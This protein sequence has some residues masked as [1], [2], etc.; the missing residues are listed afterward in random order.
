MFGLLPL[1]LTL[2]GVI[3]WII[4]KYTYK[5]KAQDFKLGTN[6][7]VTTFAFFF[8]CYPQ[9]TSISFSLFNCVSFEDG[10]QYL[11][12]DM[13]IVCWEGEH[14]RMALAIGM[15]FIIIWSFVFPLIV[16]W[17]LKKGKKYLNT[18]HYLMVYGLFYVGLSDQA[19]FWELIIVNIRKIIFILC[20]S[21]ISASNQQ[22]KVS[23]IESY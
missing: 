22:Y 4:V 21:I 23:F 17:R 8:I 2:L 19:Y 13:N 10:K 6:V 11:K 15:P 14:M 16:L 5:R 18:P 20:G 3:F 9:I 1:G 7:L 12:R